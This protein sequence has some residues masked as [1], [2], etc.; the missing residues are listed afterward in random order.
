M[1]LEGFFEF[2]IPGFRGTG[3]DKV[4]TLAEARNRYRNRPVFEGP[5][6]DPEAASQP[7]TEVEI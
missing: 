4:D 6:Y 1:L 7:A 3:P 5:T 2:E